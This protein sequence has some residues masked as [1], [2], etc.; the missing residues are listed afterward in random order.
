MSR[1]ELRKKIAI[2]INSFSNQPFNRS[3]DELLANM[4]YASSR[5]LPMQDKTGQEFLDLYDKE[6]KLNPKKALIESWV[7]V[8]LLFQL[9]GS[10]LHFRSQT[11]LPI[12]END[13]IDQNISSYLFF[14]LELRA[15]PYTRTVLADITREL[16]KCFLIPVM[17]VIKHG[18][19]ISIA[20]IH[21]RPNKR[22]SDKY[23]LEKVTLIKD[24]KIDHPHRA[25]IEILADLSLQEINAQ[26]SPPKSMEDLHQIWQSILDLKVLNKN[27]YKELS[28]WYFWANRECTFPPEAGPGETRNPTSIIR[29]ITRLIFVWFI[30]EKGLVSDDLFEKSVIQGLLKSL[31]KDEST[32]YKA[33]LQNLFFATLNQEDRD[34]RQF[35]DEEAFQGKNKQYGVF[36]VFRY[37]DFFNQPEEALRGC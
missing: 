3:A 10:D 11:A 29:L 22:E 19:K 37:K 12:S 28:N 27:F 7:G 14:A 13:R 4:G 5:R 17:L 9:T 2:T 31:K 33:I 20:I 32:Y 26:P 21:R 30:K 25:H 8:D 16:N 18:E 6:H 1:E 15:A 34:K 23:V 35:L 36:N 24:I